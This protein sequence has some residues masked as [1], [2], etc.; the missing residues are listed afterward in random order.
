MTILWL[1]LFSIYLWLS[2]YVYHI[3]IITDQ[4][5]VREEV[6][7][8]CCKFRSIYLGSSA[9]SGW[10]TQWGRQKS[11]NAFFVQIHKHSSSVSPIASRQSFVCV[12]HVWRKPPKTKPTRWFVFFSFC[13]DISC[14]CN[15]HTLLQWLYILGNVLNFGLANREKPQLLPCE[16]RPN[17]P[18]RCR[19]IL[20]WTWK[21]FER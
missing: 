13:R 15:Y 16:E 18:C 8:E 12:D 11:R 9:E 3:Y 19:S 5:G 4:S 17:K 1:D 10:K 6:K 14:F 2:W 7:L 21:C 20:C